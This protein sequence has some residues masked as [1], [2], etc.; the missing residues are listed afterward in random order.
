M[1]TLGRAMDD[2][3]DV[4]AK[5][6]SIVNIEGVTLH[7]NVGTLCQLR[8]NDE[9]LDT[10]IVCAEENREEASEYCPSPDEDLGWAG[11]FVGGNTNVQHLTLHS[12]PLEESNDSLDTFFRGA[13]RNSSIWELRLEWIDLSNGRAIDAMEPFFH[14]NTNL[15]ESLQPTKIIAALDGL[16]KLKKLYLHQM[17]IR[18]TGCVSLSLLSNLEKLSLIDNEINDYG[19]AALRGAIENG[20][21]LRVLDL[22]HNPGISIRGY[23]SIA[24]MMK[25]STS[26]LTRLKLLWNN[27][28]DERANILASALGN[29]CTLSVLVLVADDADDADDQFIARQLGIDA[30]DNVITRRGWWAFAKALCDTTSIDATYESNHTLTGLTRVPKNVPTF[31]PPLLKFSLRANRLYRANK[32]HLLLRKIQKQHLGGDTG[33][34]VLSDMDRSVLPL[35]IARLPDHPSLLWPLRLLYRCVRNLPSQFGRGIPLDGSAA[36]GL[37]LEHSRWSRESR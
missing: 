4:Y 7:A 1:C 34:R 21:S 6:A 19:V 18:S 26:N 5:L 23:K 15:L 9:S 27:V 11:H 25:S 29:G 28:D 33:M 8:D 31:L 3:R 14:N 16:S 35:F 12:L 30:R 10:L 32:G 22:S 13:S 2:L 20:S 17:G 24:C 37:T 36:N